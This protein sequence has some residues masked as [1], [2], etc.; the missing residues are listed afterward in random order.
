[1]NDVAFRD[2]RLAFL[3]EGR[4][5]VELLSELRAVVTRLVVFGNLP[6]MYS[7]TGK[8]DEDAQEEVFADWADARL[9]GAGQLAALMHQTGTAKSFGRLAEL[10]LR[11]HLINRL[12]RTHA[13][14]LFGRL[15]TVLVEEAAVFT[16]L[17]VSAREQDVVWTLSGDGA[18]QVAYA[19][20]E[21]RL[22][23]LAWSLGEF[24][25]VRFR[26][27]AKKLSHVLERDEL[28]RFVAGLIAAAAGGLTLAQIVRTIVVRFDLEPAQIEDLGREA[29]EVVVADNVVAEV[30]A[31]QLA[32]GVLGELTARQVDILT[33]QLQHESVRAIA[34]TVHVSVGT[35]STEQ[36]RIAAVLSRVSDPDHDSRRA[37]L[38]ALRDLLF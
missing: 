29:E 4:V 37:L 27:D 26:E 20:G 8:W 5:S 22:L 25:T 3:R 6:P 33:G 12:D 32:A 24:E 2:A 11:R 21:D 28:I 13:T 30:S 17:I 15:R 16:V 7:P 34:E 36:Q 38:N 19:A 35:V 18:P 1:M 10:Y 31:A 23:S 14:N 9:V